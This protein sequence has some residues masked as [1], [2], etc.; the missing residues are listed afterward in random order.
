MAETKNSPLVRSQT[1]PSDVHHGIT[2]NVDTTYSHRLDYHCVFRRVRWGNY[3]EIPQKS[4]A[5]ISRGVPQNASGWQVG[6]RGISQGPAGSH[7]ALSGKSREMSWSPAVG[8]RAI[9]FYI[10]GTPL[11][12]AGFHGTSHG[13]LQKITQKNARFEYMMVPLPLTAVA[14]A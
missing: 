6:T 2:S 1:K 5:G 12:L 7:G 13:I 4:H 10:H 11:K 14:G 3:H 8:S 9:P